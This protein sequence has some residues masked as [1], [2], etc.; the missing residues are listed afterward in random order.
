MEELDRVKDEPEASQVEMDKEIK[1]ETRLPKRGAK[2]EEIKEETGVPKRGVKRAAILALPVEAE[3]VVPHLRRSPPG[4]RATAL[5]EP[6]GSSEDEDNIRKP[7]D[8]RSD[9][10]EAF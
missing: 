6:F 10:S 3:P 1:E 8:P 7:G 4:L 2:R 5:L 9:T